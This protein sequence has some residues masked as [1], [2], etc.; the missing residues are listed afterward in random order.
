MSTP[1]EWIYLILLL[2]F[3]WITSQN[4]SPHFT[5][6]NLRLR[7]L[8]YTDWSNL[9][10]NLWQEFPPETYGES[11]KPFNFFAQQRTS[12]IYVYV[13]V[14]ACIYVCVSVSLSTTGTF[15]W[16]QR[17]LNGENTA[18]KNE[19]IHRAYNEFINFAKI[20]VTLIHKIIPAMKRTRIHQQRRHSV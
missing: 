15:L 9:T 10:R 13:Y 6:N 1:D 4:L 12:H 7:W 20:K 19:I 8:C 18:L 11:Y 16:D 5:I 14:Y 3:Q 17:C 2:F